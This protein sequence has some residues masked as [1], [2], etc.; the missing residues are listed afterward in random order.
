VPLIPS[1]TRPGSADPYVA[2]NFAVEIGGII[3]AGFSEVGGLQMEVEVVDY[4]EGGRN[5]FVHK[6]GGPARYAS[7]LTMK[8]GLSASRGLWE[9]H[10]LALKGVIVRAPIS[11]L[12]R[13][14]DGDE[15]WRW[16]FRDAYPVKWIGPDLRASQNAVAIETLE[17]VHRGLDA[18]SSG[19]R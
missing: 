5:D 7:N 18:G 1:P 11:V 14:A 17:F 10:Q 4:R 8:R 12:L 19:P 13:S 9:W 3:T 16:D 15:V 2:F 6:F